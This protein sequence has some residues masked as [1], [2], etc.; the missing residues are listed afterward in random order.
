MF[1]KIFFFLTKLIKVVKQ[2]NILDILFLSLSLSLSFSNIISITEAK[3]PDGGHLA[4]TGLVE[5]CEKR[6][7]DRRGW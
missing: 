3:V 4:R 7:G 5:G 6:R 1:T 2:I